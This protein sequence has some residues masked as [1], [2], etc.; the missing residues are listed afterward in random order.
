MAEGEQT[1]QAQGEAPVTEGQQTE[2]AQGE[3]PMAEGQQTEQAQGERPWPK[4]RRPSRRRRRSRVRKR[5]EQWPI[6]TQGISEVPD[7]WTDGRRDRRRAA[8]GR[9]ARCRLSSSMRAG[10]S[11]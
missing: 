8:V 6:S 10:S 11:E 4:V 3:A 1:E 5:R 9:K 2:Q 7:N